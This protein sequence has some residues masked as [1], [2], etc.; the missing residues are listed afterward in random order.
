MQTIEKD[1]HPIFNYLLGLFDCPG[2]KCFYNKKEKLV[3]EIVS[4]IENY[5]ISVR[6]SKRPAIKSIVYPPEA[7]RGRELYRFNFIYGSFT[8]DKIG[9]FRNF[10][11]DRIYNR[12]VHGPL[13]PRIS[14]SRG[15][16]ISLDKLI[17]LIEKSRRMDFC[18][19]KIIDQEEAKEQDKEA[20]EIIFKNM[21][22]ASN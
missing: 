5:E 7:R 3:I 15:S 18:S 19:G 12:S 11:G 17:V 8:V 2:Y 16:I 14:N 10:L 6:L 13:C 1:W 22:I 4:R 9:W 20:Q 21:E